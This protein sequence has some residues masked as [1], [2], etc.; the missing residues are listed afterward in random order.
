MA[1]RE[2]S[3]KALLVGLFR[4]RQRRD[5]EDVHA[6]CDVTLSLPPGTRLGVLGC[7]G[8]G[9]STLLKAIAGLYPLS[10]GEIEVRGRIRALLELGLGFEPDATGR[11]NVLY[12]GLLLGQTPMTM[13]SLEDEIVAFADLGE[14]IDMPL[15]TYSAGMTV[16]LAFAI[17][18]A[19]D[20][21]VLLIDEVFGAGDANFQRKARRRIL[22]MIERSRVLVFASHDL[23]LLSEL[24]QKGIVLSRGRVVFEGSIETAIAFY[25]EH[26]DA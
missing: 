12:R 6:L 1:F 17:S 5:C 7:N 10:G 22:G 26:S 2:R 24:C 14:F 18:T 21:E 8:A 4:R 16:R 9:K 25:R 15:K 23:G 3:A 13:R 11:E 20:G 19:I